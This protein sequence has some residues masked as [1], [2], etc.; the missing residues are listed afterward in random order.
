MK[1]N[2]HA[3]VATAEFLMIFWMHQICLSYTDSDNVIL[4]QETETTR[5]SNLFLSLRN[6]L[7][8]DFLLNF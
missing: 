4:Q 7:G 2:V 1:S 8:L 5:V 6:L 3:H